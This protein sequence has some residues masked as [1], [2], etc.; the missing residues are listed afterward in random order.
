MLLLPFSRLAPLGIRAPEAH[1]ER[2][3]LFRLITYFAIYSLPLLMEQMLSRI[4]EIEAYQFMH[5]MIRY[6]EQLLYVY[7]ERF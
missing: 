2:G 4:V 6:E 5:K 3:K 1:A 7:R